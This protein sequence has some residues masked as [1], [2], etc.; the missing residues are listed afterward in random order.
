[1]SSKVV[2]LLMAMGILFFGGFLYVLFD[3]VWFLMVSAMGGVLAVIS[4][5]RL[6]GSEPSYEI[7]PFCNEHYEKGFRC[8]CRRER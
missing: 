1:M 7:C 8:G 6:F 2:D 3:A 5:W 4:M